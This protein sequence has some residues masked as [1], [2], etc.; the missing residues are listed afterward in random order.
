M[1]TAKNIFRKLLCITDQTEK[2]VLMELLLIISAVMFMLTGCYTAPEMIP[3]VEVTSSE[4]PPQDMTFTL[5]GNTTLEMK[6]IAPG[7]FVMG[8]QA[9]A[10]LNTVPGHKVTITKPFWLGKYELT[11]KQYCAVTGEKEYV[12]TPPCQNKFGSGDNLPVCCINWEKAKAF[13]EKLNMLLKDSLP[14]GYRFDLPSEAQWEYACKAGTTAAF[15]DDSPLPVIPAS[16]DMPRYKNMRNEPWVASDTSAA[17]DLLAWYKGNSSLKLHNVGLKRPNGW[18][19]YDMHGNV[20]EWCLDTYDFYRKTA[21]N[22]SAANMID[23]LVTEQNNI[24]SSNRHLA[25]T[26]VLRGGNAF[27]PAK[28]LTSWNRQFSIPAKSPLGTG[29]RLALTTSTVSQIDKKDNNFYSINLHVR[30]IQEKQA[31]F[32]EKMLLRQALVW[33]E[34]ALDTTIV[35]LEIANEIENFR[36]QYKNGGAQS[37]SAEE[38][39]SGAGNIRGSS[40]LRKGGT[41]VYYLYINGRKITSPAVNWRAA[42]TS[43]SVNDCGSYARVMAGNPPIRS[44]K[45][46]TRIEVS[47]QGRTFSKSISIAK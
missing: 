38:N 21:D 32:K 17:L 6:G 4:I 37:F 15:N 36:E 28:F 25:G 33:G 42:G 29:I 9:C 43:I 45:F 11:Q 34:I 5:P 10:N 41:A 26:K 22:I 24:R 46:N 27:L 2:F 31:R 39:I 12:H 13:T 40:S 7:V 20:S 3:A 23:P 44:G 19:L 1:I 47:F 35:A 16:S 8:R 30:Q 14:A 18:G